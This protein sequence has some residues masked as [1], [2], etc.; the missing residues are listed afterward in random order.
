MRILS[1]A[2][3]SCAALLAV[4]GAIAD[5][6]SLPHQKPGL[7]HEAVTADGKT[8]TNLI[9]LDE[10]SETRLSAL[11]VQVG[12]RSC[13]SREVGHNQDGSWTVV[14]ACSFGGTWKTVNHS[15]VTGDF[16]SKITTV[17]DATFTGAPAGTPD[18]AHRV[19]IVATWQGPCQPGQKGGDVVM[20]NGTT[21]NIL[22]GASH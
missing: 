12:K 21:I 18:G 2:G 22:D 17:T 1:I 15:E 14:A 11:G 19:V 13:Q 20:S 8:S 5:P 7:W 9:C 4:G 3:I 16:D 10:A 6:M